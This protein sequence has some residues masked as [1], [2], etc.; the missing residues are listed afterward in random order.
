MAGE[1]RQVGHLDRRLGEA[2]R[3]GF[4]RAVVPMLAP[5]VDADLHCLRVASLREAIELIA[6]P[7]PVGG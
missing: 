2:A 6:Q 7:S 1:L 3:L 5:E 4:T